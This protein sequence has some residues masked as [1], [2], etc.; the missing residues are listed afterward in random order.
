MRIPNFREYN[1]CTKFSKQIVAFILLILAFAPA[2][3]AQNASTSWEKAWG[4]FFNGRPLVERDESKQPSQ[5][6][7]IHRWNRIAIDA[8]GLDH[9]PLKPGE[10]RIFGEQL[11]PGRASRAMAIVH[12][13]IFD[14]VNA[15]QGGFHSYT[16]LSPAPANTSVD[17]AVVVAAHDTLS[18]M[19]P[20]QAAH[21]DHLLKN[22]L[23]RITDSKSKS[24][25]TDLG[26]RAAAK[27]LALRAD[28]GSNYEE[29]L[30][31]SQFHTS[32]QPGK[33]RQDPIS[34][35]PIALG[36]KWGHVHPFVI[37]SVAAFRVPPP[38]AMSSLKYASA[39]NEVKRLGGD[40]IHTPTARTEEQTFIGI[41]WAY[42]GT[43][44][45][46]APPRL[47]NQITVAIADRRGTTSGTG[48]AAR[49]SQ[50]CDGRCRNCHL[51][52]QV[53]L[54]MLAPHH[55]NSRIGSGNWSDSTRRPQSD[56]SRRSRFHATRRA[57]EQSPGSELYTALSCVSIGTCWIWWCAVPNP[58]QFLRNR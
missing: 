42:D 1:S 4:L 47:Y 28:D 31:G 12:I 51:G 15:I 18:A 26:H 53:P 25:G 54:S 41:F 52:I 14:A 56:D 13:A 36:A 49:F 57:R 9:T 58:A 46:C 27:I 16:G 34:K 50:C 44:S 43:P 7:S 40:G 10:T 20:S 30:M 39:F 48:P 35:I 11:G 32:D 55:R 23:S 29:P 21:F 22:D 6:D 19:F 8:S 3:Q 45:L 5:S 17:A 2:I 37:G 24:D 33:W 38:P